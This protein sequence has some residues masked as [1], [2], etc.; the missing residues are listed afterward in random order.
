MG[1]F[2]TSPAKTEQTS[3]S[4][5]TANPWDPAQPLLKKV[6][7]DYGNLDPSLTGQ[8]TTAGGNLWNAAS[9]IPSLAPQATGA[10]QNIFQ[11]AGMLPDAYKAMQGN[12]SPIASMNVNPWQT[13]GFSDAMNT[14]MGNI[15]NKVKDVYA[16]SGRSP[17]GAGTFGKS[18]ALGL[19]QGMAPIIQDQY[20][21]NLANMMSANSQLLTGGINTSSGMS[22]QMLTALQG[23]G[24]IPG[25]SMAPATAQWGAANAIQGQPFANMNPLL[26]ASMGL[27]GM[28]GTTQATGTQTGTQEPASSGIS[29][30]LGAISGIAG[31]AGKLPFSDRR[32]KTDVKDIGRTHDNQKIYSYRFKGSSMP[33]IGMMADEIEKK[34]PDAVQRDPTS[35][36]KRVRY[37]LA[38]RK[39]A[40]MGMMPAYR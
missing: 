10:V 17:S 39:A 6:V 13:P 27:G 35:G 30:V 1:F 24:M 36:Y 40:K 31:L 15:T 20:N 2:D 8:Q 28:G 21:K 33:Q 9:S 11:N 34:T 16:S 18:E 32:L 29:N 12:L 26:A 14:M 22:N 3:S 38:T 37:D 7:G 25:I 5:T 4:T 19:T 23:A